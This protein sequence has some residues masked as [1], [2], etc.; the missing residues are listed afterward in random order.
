MKTSYLWLK[1]LAPIKD[2]A[3]QLANRMT[4]AGVEIESIERAGK[5][6]ILDVAVPP[7]RG[8]LLGHEGIAHEAAAILKFALPRKKIAAPKGTGKIRSKLTV[9]VKDRVRAPRYMARM[10]HGIKVGPSPAWLVD[11]LEK[12]GMRSINNIV[13]VTNY[14]MLELG[15][16]MHAFDYDK[17][18]EHSLTI[19]TPPAPMRMT[20]LD[21][22]EHSLTTEDVCI[23]DS[24]GPVAIGGIIGGLNSSVSDTSTVIVLESAYFQPSAIRRSSRRLG[25]STESSRR[26]ERSVDPDTVDRALHRA[27]Q[28]IVQLAGGTP[29][30]DWIDFY[31]RK[32]IPARITFAAE[33]VSKT[34]GID[35]KSPQIVKYLTSVGCQVRPKGAGKWQ[36]VMPASRPDL[37]RAI[38][39]IEEIVRL[40]GY[41]EIPATSPRLPATPATESPMRTLCKRVREL[42]TGAGLSE[43]IHYGFEPANDMA[44]A[45]REQAIEITNPLGTEPTVLRGELA[46]GCVSAIAFNLRHRTMQGGLFELRRVFESTG[47]G[48]NDPMH[49][50]V[51]LFGTRAGLHWTGGKEPL[52][53]FDIKGVIEHLSHGL[54]LPT[55]KYNHGAVPRYIHPRESAV[56]T[57]GNQTI[58]WVGALHPEIAQQLEITVHCYLAEL[59]IEALLKTI[60]SSL[61]K[62]APIPRFPGVRRDVAILVDLARS[63]EELEAIIR[64]AGGKL[65]SNVTLFDY[66]QGK[67][68]PAD[69]KSLAYALQYQ[70]FDETL[71]DEAVTKLHES[72]VKALTQQ[73]GAVIR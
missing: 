38:D 52:D 28:L 63:A 72:V 54:A 71:T 13:D 50:C 14:V 53:F 39:L 9:T 64:K 17:L 43:T 12:L 36:V 32:V 8:D 19:Q 21:G 47:S 20:T 55:L 41:D 33:M 29:S 34:L 57:L 1:E 67:N 48:I 73:V 27:T 24:G 10:I 56:L 25:I 18:R 37:T 31:P 15:Q 59:N 46:P 30:A 62:V 22:E 35:I 70:N 11:R 60:S 7:N 23:M 49:L 61:I 6:F 16:P 5:D 44:W 4:M 58:G 3:Q 26:F 45:K 66:Y 69:K 68:I 2:S 51:A 65:L 42:M 40:H